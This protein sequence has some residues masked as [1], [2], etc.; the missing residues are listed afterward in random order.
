[1]VNNYNQLIQ[2]IFIAVLLSAV[3]AL[4]SFGQAINSS[5]SVSFNRSTKVQVG[6]SAEQ[7]NPLSAVVE[8]EFNDQIQTVGQAIRK[9]LTDCGF[10]LSNE[11]PAPEQNFLMGL[12]LPQVHQSLGPMTVTDALKILGGEG[13]TVETNPIAR[14]V[15][16]NLKED[17]RH[18]FENL[19]IELNN[20]QILQA[21]DVDPTP[22]RQKYYGPV[23]DGES[24]SAIVSRLQWHDITLN[25]ALVLLFDTNSNSFANHNMNHLLVGSV[26]QI[27]EANTQS[28]SSVQEANTIVAQHNQAWIQ[29]K[30]G[31]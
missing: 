13:Y 24:L 15:T 20:P 7:L 12:P 11:K 29:N 16:Y 8:I 25:Q 26:L 23:I 17:Y 22:N 9:I 21:I 5:Q 1:M 4:P 14:T 27:P 2:R 30:E 6:V 19:T 31:K 3:V 18:Y 10:R 28:I